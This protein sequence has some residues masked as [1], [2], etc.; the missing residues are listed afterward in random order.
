[1]SLISA[2]HTFASWAEGELAKLVKDEPK[3]EHVADTVLTYVGGAASIIAG[4]EGGTAAS[5]AVSGV[6]TGIRTGVTAL[7]GLITDFGPTPTAATLAASI[8]ANANSLLTAGHVTN[9]VSL[10]AANGIITN[11]NAL[12]QALTTKPDGPQEPS[13]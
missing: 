12:A 2:L 6:L 8:A 3:I 10:K 9:P 11:L 7:S 5:T 1:M 13:N 4:I